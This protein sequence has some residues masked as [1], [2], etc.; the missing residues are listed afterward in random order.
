VLR[1]EYSP[2]ALVY[3]VSLAWTPGAAR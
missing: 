2:S 3:G 1:G